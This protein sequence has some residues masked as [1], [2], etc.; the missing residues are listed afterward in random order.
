MTGFHQTRSFLMRKSQ[1]LHHARNGEISGIAVMQKSDALP[2]VHVRAWWKTDRPLF[3]G[4][5][6]QRAPATSSN[7]KTVNP[8]GQLRLWNAC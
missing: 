7:G 1:V 6:P 4:G 3:C 5:I 8:E 2:V